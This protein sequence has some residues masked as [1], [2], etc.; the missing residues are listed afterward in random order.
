[1]KI[2][3]DNFI[4]IKLDRTN[5]T[6]IDFIK[7]IDND[8]DIKKYLYPYNA[9]FDDF[10]DSRVAGFDIF[11]NFYIV[12]YENRIIGYIEIENYKNVFI[13]CALLKNER[14]KGFGSKILSELTSY[15]LSNYP[16]VLSVNTIIRN[17]NQASIHATMKS[18][19]EFIENKDGF[20][21]YGKKR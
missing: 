12:Y 8:S 15:I 19:F 10:I 17:E 14:N 6:H 13:N 16:N 1:M 2:I 7:K 11:N 4:L 20:S 5:D 18:G 3:L 9:T 21:T